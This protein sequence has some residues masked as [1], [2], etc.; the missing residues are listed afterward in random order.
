MCENGRYTERGIK[1]RHGFGSERFTLE[2]EFAYNV[3][4]A[5]GRCGVLIEPASV[6]AKAWEN[7]DYFARRAVFRPERVLVT[8]AGPIGLLAALL[9]QQRGYEVHVLD[10][11]QAGP[12]IELVQSLGAQYHCGRIE[13]LQDSVDIVLECTGAPEVVADAI[14]CTGPNR[15]VCL[16]G[17]S[18]GTRAVQ[19]K[20][21]RLNNELVLENGVVFGS[22]NANRR[23]YAAGAAA[24]ERAPRAWL[25]R[26]LSPRLPIERFEDA[27]TGHSGGI[28][29][30][31]EF[32][33]AAELD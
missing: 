21:S 30:I 24:L 29:T 12:K 1:E 33:A 25:E 18:S 15:I 19:L 26:M 31:L 17:V 22:V 20:A 3:P 9:A 16:A 8:G 23:H 14:S 2:P 7:I 28:K 13:M 5:L 6:V 10:R 32:A 4:P 27:F 11:V